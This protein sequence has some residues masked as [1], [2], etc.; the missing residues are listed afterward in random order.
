MLR[1]PSPA[2]GDENSSCCYHIYVVVSWWHR[3]QPIGDKH[4]FMRGRVAPV[5]GLL[6]TLC[7]IRHVPRGAWGRRT[8][9]RYV[10]A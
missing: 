9:A 3:M 8:P 1:A 2:L 5:P 4:C 10:I 6:I 7:S